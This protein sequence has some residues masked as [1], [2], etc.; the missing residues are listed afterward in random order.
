MTTPFPTTTPVAPSSTDELKFLD[1]GLA[2]TSAPPRPVQHLPKE[3]CLTPTRALP[4]GH[5]APTRPTGSCWPD[6]ATPIVP[7]CMDE[8]NVV[9]GVL[10]KT[11]APPRPVQH[12]LQEKNCLSPTRRAL[13]AGHHAP[14]LHVTIR[15]GAGGHRPTNSADVGKGFPVGV[16]DPSTSVSAFSACCLGTTSRATGTPLAHGCS[17]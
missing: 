16:G 5:H 13:L 14:T 3:I 10:K 12:L 1:D 17:V 2:R 6:H 9:V 4:A 7:R 15:P 8:S 11:N